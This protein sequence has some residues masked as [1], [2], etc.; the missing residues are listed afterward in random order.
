MGKELLVAGIE[1]S[2]DET[3]VAVLQGDRLLSS[4]VASQDAE[5]A[6]YGGVVP[7][8]AARRHLEVLPTLW[9][10]ALARADVTAAELDGIAV[11]RGPGLAGSLLTGVAFARGLARSLGKPIVG[12]NHVRAH[13]AAARLLPVPPQPP[14]LGLIVSGG[15]TE[16]LWVKDW[17]RME[18]LG[19]TLDDAA[20]EALDKGARLLG[21]GYPGGALLEELAR[22]GNPKAQRFTVPLAKDKSCNF[23][24]SGL[25]TAL[26]LKVRGISQEELGAAR[27]D[28]AA[29][30][31]A[32][33]VR[34]L[35]QRTVRA[36]ESIQVA[37]VVA[38]G[39]VLANSLL[40]A[41]LG[42]AF[43]DRLFIPLREFCGDNGAMVAALGILRL[44]RGED[45][46]ATMTV[47]VNWGADWREDPQVER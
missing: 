8:L 42:C 18:R 13:L 26:M 47:A 5:H 36:A 44:A 28:L 23:S 34:H 27:A 29:A 21:L 38:A 17:E 31:Q 43:G 3:A 4:L 20:G 19:Q 22:T 6:P 46:G 35:V 45:D 12:V 24:F 11:T 9:D 1:S 2:C 10:G 16:L 30:Y 14:F 7:E 39:G 25:K 41:E 40:R 37:A 32:V 15:H 33:V